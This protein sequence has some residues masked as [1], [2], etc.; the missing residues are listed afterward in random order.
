MLWYVEKLNR[1]I[2]KSQLRVVGLM[3]G[4]SMDGLDICVA[5]IDLSDNELDFEIVHFNSIPF[6][7]HIRDKIRA[8]ISG[9][10]AQVCALNFELGKWYADYVVQELNSNH[11]TNI[12]LI[13]SHGQTLHHIS[14]HSTLQIGDPT[15]L[16]QTV[17][18]PV[19]YDFRAADIAAGGTG[20]PLI[21][22]IDDWLFRHHNKARIAVN[23]GGVA[24]VTLLPPQGQGDVQGFDTGPGM[25]L[26]DEA[27]QAATGE[28][29]DLDGKLAGKGRADSQLVTE[30]L[31]DDFI[32]KAPPKSTG[33]DQYGTEWLAA[34]KSQ[35]AHLPIEDR[36]ATLAVFTAESIHRNCKSFLQQYNSDNLIVGGGGVHHRPLMQQLA[37]LFSGQKTITSA[38]FGV[39]PDAKEALGFA[40]LAVAFIKAIPGNLPSVT[41]ADKPVVLGKLVL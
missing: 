11:I 8:T 39:D 28:K 31:L 10:T 3:S 23:I 6:D 27:C 4:T 30:W 38:E 14:G 16:A 19:I 32:T 29:Y 12:D 24:N 1:L 36:L 41:G 15:Y 21:P 7:D 20:A 34:H 9:T 26:L 25:A 2:K 33:R 22:R 18:V 40:V 13:G 17:G 5:D 35:L 37:R